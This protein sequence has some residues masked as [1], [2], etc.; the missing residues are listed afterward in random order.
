MANVRFGSKADIGARL[1]HVR[2][3]PKSR[4]R[5]ARMS[6]PLCAKSGH[7][8]RF[9]RRVLRHVAKLFL[10][11]WFSFQLL[12]PICIKNHPCLFHIDMRPSFGVLIVFLVITGSVWIIANLNTNMMSI[13]AQ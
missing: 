10:G 11:Q 6:C 12:K 2:F 7:P 9:G 8:D 1:D 3:T 13:A 4:H 5:G